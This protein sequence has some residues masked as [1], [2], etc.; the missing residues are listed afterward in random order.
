M[1]PIPY[2]LTRIARPVPPAPNSSVARTSS[3]TFINP[4]VRAMAPA[5]P[6][7][8]RASGSRNTCAGRCACRPATT[9]PPRGPR[10]DGRARAAGEEQRGEGERGA[11]DDQH[12][13]GPD[14]QQHDPRTRGTEGVAGLTGAAVERVAGGEPRVG[15][16]AREQRRRRRPEQRRGDAGDQRQRDD[17]GGRVDENDPDE[18]RGADEVG[19]DGAA[20]AARAVDHAAHQRAEEHQRHEL[21]EQ[22]RGGRPR[23]PDALVG[24]QHQGDVAGAGADGALQVGGEEPP[25][26]PL[27]APEGQHPAHQAAAVGMFWISGMAPSFARPARDG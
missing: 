16:E 18:G 13:L 17:G 22:D 4:V 6:I 3:A 15:H 10:P 21:S 23:G 12:G 1:M 27:L 11:V 19:D 26:A 7:R 5:P 14:D 8:I 9:R 2:A 25:G 20:E 24:Q